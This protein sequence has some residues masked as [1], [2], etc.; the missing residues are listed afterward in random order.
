MSESSLNYN[1][2]NNNHHDYKLVC[3]VIFI[4]SLHGKKLTGQSFPIQLTW[5]QD[6]LLVSYSGK[7]EKYKFVNLK[8]SQQGVDHTIQS[9]GLCLVAQSNAINQ[10]T[11]L[12]LEKSIQHYTDLKNNKNKDKRKAGMSTS[13]VLVVAPS[14]SASSSSST[15]ALLS[16]NKKQRIE[17]RIENKTLAPM[18]SY[19]KSSGP[20]RRDSSPQ[21]F[22][23]SSSSLVGVGRKEEMKEVVDTM[24]GGNIGR[25]TSSP[26]LRKQ[27]PLPRSPLTDSIGITSHTPSSLPNKMIQSPSQPSSSSSSS[28]SVIA[29]LFAPKP[30][31][32]ARKSS[33]VTY[34]LSSTNITDNKPY[35]HISPS[36]NE[37]Y[38]THD[39]EKENGGEK[40]SSVKYHEKGNKTGLDVFLDGSQS[41][42][43]Q[44]VFSL[45]EKEKQQ[46]Q[47]DAMLATTQKATKA[48][49]NK[50]FSNT[51]EYLSQNKIT[52]SEV[53]NNSDWRDNLWRNDEENDDTFHSPL[54]TP[55][56]HLLK[57]S[58]YLPPHQPNSVAITSY[59]SNKLD[60]DDT[61]DKYRI[62]RPSDQQQ[63]QQRIQLSM[64][65]FK[66][67]IRNLGNS[68]YMSSILQA[69]FALPAFK[70]NI[71]AVFWSNRQV[72]SVET[73][74]A[75]ISL[76]DFSPST[77]PPPPPPHHIPAPSEPLH[78]TCLNEF[79][80]LLRQHGTVQGKRLDSLEEQMLQRRAL[81]NA[82]QLPSINALRSLEDT[83]DLATFKKMM[84]K[85]ASIFS[86]YLQQDAHEYLTTILSI[87]DE[88]MVEM[89]KEFAQGMN[90]L[91]S[92]KN[93]HPQENWR[94]SSSSSPDVFSPTAITDIPKTVLKN[95]SRGR[96]EQEAEAAAGEV[97]V[98]DPL[99]TIRGQNEGTKEKR[100]GEML[101][102][103]DEVL[104]LRD[105]C[106][107]TRK[108][109]SAGLLPSVVSDSDSASSAYS[110][111]TAMSKGVD[112]SNSKES[113]KLKWNDNL[114]HLVQKM[115]PTAF[116]FE[117][118]MEMSLECSSCSYRHPPR[119]EV[120]RDFSLHLGHEGRAVE[121]SPLSVE[122]LVRSF[123]QEET[124]ELHCPHCREGSQV[125]LSKR[126]L[127]MAP[128]LVLH[129]KRFHYD[130]QT[131]G[132]TKLRHPISF[133]SKLD[134]KDCGIHPTNKKEASFFRKKCDQVVNGRYSGLWQEKETE[135]AD[136]LIDQMQSLVDQTSGMLDGGGHYALR[137]V[138][139][140]MGNALDQG[141]Y[142]CDVVDEANGQW[143][144]CNDALVMQVSEEKVLEERETPYI[145]FFEFVDR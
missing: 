38:I 91:H 4:S 72:K 74:P 85:R 47:R 57:S 10:P 2:Y 107:T 71:D 26:A 80:R 42:Q 90:D 29:N 35:L 114:R 13:S 134:L 16:N 61:G 132:Y 68:C 76:E 128:C 145:L 129:L 59:F 63:Q 54:R 64:K 9:D 50:F 49:A 123:L 73:L 58:S 70:K 137:A 84:G 86:G 20:V 66:G 95:P 22:S 34:S 120:Y 115:I 79:L 102:D 104:S 119:A 89:V 30:K 18:T 27:Q 8:L 3:K 121:D 141:H 43:G 130:M 87:L 110:A 39:N 125:I 52:T 67:G 77:P 17:P 45:K 23:S 5:Q 31:T 56:D 113:N 14:S 99:C 25:Y 142:I 131:G 33:S 101:D 21:Q 12:A 41:K 126:M 109:D 69:L 7:T 108:R 133:T 105:V 135:R 65:M 103:E 24:N 100:G 106:V 19:S 116:L 82:L 112:K 75:A 32:F 118:S 78:Q 144:R 15:A 36:M 88:D 40:Q 96:K 117:S 136:K 140:H 92:V 37:S 51:R 62:E 127:Q 93:S 143:L 111:I 94:R 97:D 28:S 1:N 11:L 124:R 6:K 138:V 55:P 53:N 46:Q 98:L 44:I 122:S 83:L 81:F 139:R 48:D 60:F